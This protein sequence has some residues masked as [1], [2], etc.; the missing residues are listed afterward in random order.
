MGENASLSNAVSATT[1]GAVTLEQDAYGGKSGGSDGGSGGTSGTGTS[2][3]TVTQNGVSSVHA[4]SNASGGDGGT[5]QGAIASAGGSQ[6]DDGS[7]QQFDG[8]H[9][10]RRGCQQVFGQWNGRRGRDQ[11]GYGT[12]RRGSERHGNREHAVGTVSSLVTANAYGYGGGGGYNSSTGSGGA[13]ATG[14]ASSTANNGGTGGLTVLAV[15]GGGLGGQGAG[16]GFSGGVGGN[17]S[18]GTVSGTSSGS[19][20]VSVD[21]QEYG[22]NGGFGQSSATEEMARRGVDDQ[23]GQRNDNRHA[24]ARTG[25]VRRQQRREQRRRRRNLGNGNVQLTLHPQR[26]SGIYGISN[27]SGGNGGTSQCNGMPGSISTATI[28]LKSNGVTGRLRPPRTPTV[29]QAT[30]QAT[31]AP[32]R[33]HRNGR[34]IGAAGTA[35]APR[36]PRP[37]SSLLTVNAYGYGG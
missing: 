29:Q 33:W 8:E 15:A 32:Q 23:R 31:A 37:L 26:G 22:G 35:S 36:R 1:T 6:R 4:T 10:C 7:N 16:G 2:N 30:E 24:D 21:A 14:T 18:L 9:H 28:D 12:R 13:G 5:S 34:G 11:W 27:A 3:F 17:A 25:C 20:S 19:G